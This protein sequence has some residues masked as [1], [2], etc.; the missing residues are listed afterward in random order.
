MTLCQCHYGLKYG[1]DKCILCQQ[2]WKIRNMSNQMHFTQHSFL[3]LHWHIFTIYACLN[4]SDCAWNRHIH[5]VTYAIVQLPPMTLYQFHCGLKYGWVETIFC[6]QKWK[7]RNFSNQIC[8]TQQY[9]ILSL[10]LCSLPNFPLC[11]TCIDF[12]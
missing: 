6:Q 2:K 8:F 7:I 12:T 5:A 3:Y 4:M 1:S 9:F 11:F 10:S